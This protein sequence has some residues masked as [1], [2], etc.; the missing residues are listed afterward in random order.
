MRR[1]LRTLLF[2]VALLA[3]RSASAEL[4]VVV[5][6]QL[7]IDR[8]SHNEVVNIF[9][10][11]WRKF[12]NGITAL[13]A[14]QPVAGGQREAFYRKLVD[15][16]LSAI[17]AYWSRLYFSG[18]TNPPVDIATPTAVLEHILGKPGAIAYIDSKEVDARM[19]VVFALP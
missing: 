3:A 17:N 14:D 2:F 1:T 11:R 10:G 5:D 4:V 16:D 6:A 15:K 13:P 18:K 19:K 12:P 8:L 7:G 9:L